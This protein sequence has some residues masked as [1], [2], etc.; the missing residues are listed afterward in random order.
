MAVNVSVCLSDYPIPTPPLLGWCPKIG[1]NDAF[2]LSVRTH[3]HTH[4]YVEEGRKERDEVIRANY[5]Q[6]GAQEGRKRPPLKPDGQ[7]YEMAEE[8]GQGWHVHARMR[9]YSNSREISSTVPQISLDLDV[10]LFRY[11]CVK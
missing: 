9:A 11:V 8:K 4:I 5:I 10:F 7:G 2:W 6:A 1:F 3:A